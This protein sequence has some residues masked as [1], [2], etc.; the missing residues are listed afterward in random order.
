MKAIIAGGIMAVG[1]AMAV[2]GGMD[3]GSLG[4]TPFNYQNASKEDRTA[5]LQKESGTIG[6][7]L[8]VALVNPSGVGGSMRLADT[9][10]DPNRR[11][12]KFIIKVQGRLQP[13]AITNVRQAMLKKVCPRFV[14]SKLGRNDVRMVQSFQNSKGSLGSITISRS[15]CSR[16]V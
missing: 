7:M 16:Y 2:G 4:S 12:I 14:E 3:L 10:V 15:A 8:R 13:G 5:F 1:A 6:K 9:K 11:E